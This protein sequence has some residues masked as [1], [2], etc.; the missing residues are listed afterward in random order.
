VAI[1]RPS[2][3]V[4]DTVVRIVNDEILW[5]LRE[6]R[7]Q[8]LEQCCT[9]STFSIHLEVCPVPAEHLH[10]V[11][12]VASNVLG[13]HGPY[14]LYE[15]GKMECGSFFGDDL[16]GSLDVLLLE[17]ACYLGLE[18]YDR[19]FVLENTNIFLFLLLALVEQ[20]LAGICQI[21]II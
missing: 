20:P 16:C 14:G 10:T 1:M 19:C 11:L 7:L 21:V 2:K 15:I 12:R 9:Q 18:Q 13:V 5:I 17:I 6:L 4:E 8:C 3:S